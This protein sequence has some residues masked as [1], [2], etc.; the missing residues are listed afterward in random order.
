MNNAHIIT[1]NDRWNSVSKTELVKSGDYQEALTLA[2]EMLNDADYGSSYQISPVFHLDSETKSKVIK[3]VK[4]ELIEDEVPAPYADNCD[5]NMYVFNAFT[6]VL[7]CEL[8]LDMQT[9]LDAI[10]RVIIN[11]IY[12]EKM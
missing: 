11:I 8:D 9:S 4:K 6:E 2:D 1:I 7:G 3:L 5:L 12:K 10:G